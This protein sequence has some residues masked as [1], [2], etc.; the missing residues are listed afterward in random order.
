MSYDLFFTFPHPTE[1]QAVEQHFA[2]RQNY[3]DG[4]YQ[5]ERTGVYFSF[6]VEAD[7][8]DA[9]LVKGVAFNLNYFRPTVFGLEAEPEVRAFV[10]AF[11]PDI[12][13]P[14]TNGMASGPYSRQGFLSGWNTGNAF[15]YEAIPRDNNGPFLTMPEARM[16]AIWRWNMA[17]PEVQALIGEIA[18]VPRVTLMTVDGE[19]KSAAIWPDGIPV[20]MP[21]TDVVYVG[22]KALAP[23]PL[24]RPRRDD[25]CVLSQATLDQAAVLS[26]LAD[27][28]YALRVRKPSYVEVPKHVEMYVRGLKAFAGEVKL[29]STDSVLS[30]ELFERYWGR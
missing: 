17:V 29:V 16:E 18:F 21:E 19:L 26:S 1:A 12:E 20:L 13:D 9:R 27:A 28:G 15:A 3:R 11:E 10:D 2:G 22:R 24:F 25:R 8:A 5:N 4:F 23:K 7:E 6:E 30:R 14:Q